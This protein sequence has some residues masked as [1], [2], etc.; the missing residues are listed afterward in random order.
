MAK[1]L[2]EEIR[3]FKLA[4]DRWDSA[5]ARRLA[6]RVGS[7]LDGRSKGTRDVRASVRAF[8]GFFLADPEDL[9]VLPLVE[10]F[11]DSGTPGQGHIFRITEGND[12]LATV[13]ARRLRGTLLLRTIVRRARQRERGVTV[14]VEDGSGRRSEIE[15]AFLVC[16]LPAST[17]RDVVFEPRLPEPQHDAISACDMARRR[18]SCC[19][20]IGV[21]GSREAGPSRLERICPSGPCGTATSSS[22]VAAILSFLAGGRASSELQQILREEGP[23]GVIRGSNGS[24]VRQDC[25]RR[26]RSS[27]MRIP[28]SGAAT[29]FS[30]RRSIPSGARGSRD[31]MAGSSSP[32]STRAPGGRAT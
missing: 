21:S 30:I 7:G 32:A 29:R 23:S 22:A 10:Q 5:I 31:P 2:G 27:G 19:S 25:L 18:D 15:G 4:E 6:A 1:V 3:D 26:G 14:T 28:G 20:S 12:R 24:A 8:R 9:S 13:M 16:A 11:A 17:A